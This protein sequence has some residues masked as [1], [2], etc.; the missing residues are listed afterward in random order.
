MSKKTSLVTDIIAGIW[1]LI[2][3]FRLI[4]RAIESYYNEEIFDT[5]FL[6]FIAMILTS[7]TV[8]IFCDKIPEDIGENKGDKNE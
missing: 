6:L 8:W 2:S 7:M 3:A 5:A 1:F 4:I